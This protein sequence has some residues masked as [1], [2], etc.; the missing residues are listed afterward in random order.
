MRPC[1]RRADR[2]RKEEKGY[3]RASAREFFG[4]KMTKVVGIRFRNTC[5]TYFFDPGQIDLQVGDHAIVETAKGLEYG[6]VASG[7]RDVADE[8]VVQPLRT[9]IR[10]AS[11]RDDE[12]VAENR[13][14]EENALKV[15]QEKAREHELDMKV[16]EAEY[17]FDNSK[18]LFYF[19]AEGRVDFRELV[20]DLAAV[21]HT[22]IELRQIGVRDEARALGGFGPC[23]RPLC[24]AT[25]LNDFIAVSIKM[26]KEQNLALNP[27]KISGVCGR[28]MCCLKYEEEV[29]EELNRTMPDVGDYVEA[30][31]GIPGDVVSTNILRQTVRIVV[32]VNGDKE[33]RE[34]PA[35]QLTLLKKRKQRK[36]ELSEAAALERAQRAQRAEQAK[37]S[38]ED[39]KPDKSERPEKGGKAARNQKSVGRG[40][41]D[42]RG[43]QAPD[44]GE[45]REGR[46]ND[47]RNR[48][49]NGLAKEQGEAGS[50]AA[51]SNETKSREQEGGENRSGNSNREHRKHHHRK[52]RGQRPQGEGA[53]NGSSS[54]QGGGEA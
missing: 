50:V 42:G 37:E 27:T 33:M 20:K 23:G 39:R 34:Y 3:F 51:P 44:G 5:K 26:A 49:P 14:K 10:K 38:G 43:G 40:A 21:F 16:T 15:C 54:A 46:R 48:R 13:R 35:A 28:L 7:I 2:I 45:K 24:C 25:Y 31:D 4:E 52:N 18:I 29:Y 22:R 17:A 12:Q 36:K 9:V 32:D 53:G 41:E 6:E 30:E 19:T 11:R 47:R 1:R 8:Q